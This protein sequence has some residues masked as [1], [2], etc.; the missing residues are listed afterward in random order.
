MNKKQSLIEVKGKLDIL[1]SDMCTIIG[2]L[3]TVENSLYFAEERKDKD[4][5]KPCAVSVLVIGS[6]VDKCLDEISNIGEVIQNIIKNDIT[7]P[8]EC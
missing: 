8:K 4:M 6:M 7:N 1:T 2:C 3:E 5:T